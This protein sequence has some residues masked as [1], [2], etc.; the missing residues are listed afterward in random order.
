M[1]NKIIISELDIDVNALIKSTAEVKNAIDTIKKQQAELTKS[2]ETAS[3]QFIQNSADLKT[4]SSAYNSN[5]KAISESTQATADQANRTALLTLAIDTEVVSIKEARDQNSLLNKLRNE[6]NA[7][8]E[9]GQKEIALLNKKLDENNEFIKENA[10]AYLKQKI[11]IG[12][13][14]D[15]IKD[16]LSN[17]NP[18][19]GGLSGFIERSQQAGG[20]GSLLTASLKGITTGIIGM[21]RASLTF[22]ATPIGAVIGAIGVVLGLVIN[23]LKSTQSGIDA[24]TSVTRPLQAI[25]TSLMSVLNAVGKALFEAFSNPKKLLTDLADFVKQNLINRFKAFSVILEGIINLDFKKISNGVLQAGTGV[26]NMTDK[27]QN[28]AKATNKFLSDAIEKGKQ[29]DALKK[30]IERSELDYQRAQIKTNDLIDA[31]LLISKDTSKSFAERGKASEEIIRLTEELSKKEQ[32]IIQKKIKALQLE[33]SMKDAK[34]LTIAEQQ[35]MID[36]EKQ[37]DEAEDRG[38]NARLEQTRVLSGLKKEQQAQAE[39]AEKRNA[40]LRQKALDDAFAKSQAELNLFLATQGIKAKTIEEELK[41]AEQTYQKQLEI[42]Q[43]EFN[44]SE[45]SEI[46]K[47]D[48]LTKNQEAKNELLQSQSD[49]VIANV[50]R[51]LQIFKDANQSKLDANKFLTDELVAQEIDR[52]NRISEAEAEAQTQRFINGTINEQQYQDAI[53]QIDDN[54]ANEKKLLEEQKTQAD[55]EKKL[56]DL[57]NERAYEDL[58]FREDFDIKLQRLEEERQAELKSAEKSNADVD[59]INKLYDARARELQKQQQLAKVDSFQNAIGQIGGILNAFGV[60]NKNLA[61][62]LATADAFLSATK[63]YGSQLVIGDPTSLPRA[64]GAG[65]SALASGI[66]NV[67]QIAKTDTKFA[68]GGFIEVNGASHAQGG[69]PIEIGGQNFGTMQGGEG[70][71][72]MNKGAFNHFKAFNNTFGDSDVKGGYSSGFYASGGIITQSVQPQGIDATQL[73]NITIDAMKNLPPQYVAV[74]DINLGQNS[75]AQV[76]EGANF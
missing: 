70:L 35:A 6:A 62:A 74:T 13:Y 57:E 31:Q 18:L 3:H 61:I 12:N 16:A 15:S 60:K 38:L 42:N 34:S 75:F 25:M 1:A 68:G 27:I 23:Y 71:A 29:I 64:I 26:E 51:E 39:E 72:I 45:K 58:I 43:K 7:T 21:T 37:L 55:N 22:L 28:G 46:D 14:S 4:L 41:I 44:A 54:F 76:V 8:T 59:K 11:N 47:L 53:K 24:V 56:I 65:A 19:N 63:A 69:I 17:L 52:L 50:D 32:E 49:I 66:A 2:G 30:D 9:E 36:L 40:D 73:A 5:L 48:L 67:A 33:Y 10:D 20:V